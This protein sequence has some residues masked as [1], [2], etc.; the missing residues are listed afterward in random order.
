MA[1]FMIQATY[2]PEAWARMAQKPEDRREAVRP[3]AEK[4]GGKLIDI[5][6]CMGEYDAIVLIEAPDAASAAAASVGAYAAGHLRAIK[7][8][9]LFTVE[10]AMGVMR[11]VGSIGA[12]RTPLSS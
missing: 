6:F 12:L 3:L 11:K 1:L 10:E 4:L 7:T 9:P 8:T 2:T 5:Y